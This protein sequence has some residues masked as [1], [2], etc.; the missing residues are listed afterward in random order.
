MYLSLCVHFV[1]LY[2]KSKVPG[3]IF[4]DINAFR[5]S[6]YLGNIRQSIT[7]LLK[8]RVVNR[9]F[10][11]YSRDSYGDVKI[12]CPTV[13]PVLRNGIEKAAESSILG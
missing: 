1:M 6:R 11:V 13:Q 12:S 3:K 7:R 9:R 4:S 2:I 8:Y 5:L 10:I